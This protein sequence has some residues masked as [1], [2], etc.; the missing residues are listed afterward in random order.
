MPL[1]LQ[2]ETY[3]SSRPVA[4]SVF[5]VTD[6]VLEGETSVYSVQLEGPAAQVIA[7]TD[8]TVIT[9]T[10]VDEVTH[11]VINS[12]TEQD[13]LDI[14]G[15]SI[16]GNNVV[17]SPTALLTWTAQALDNIIVDPTDT[18]TIEWHRAIFRFEF[19]IGAGAEVGLHEVRIPVKRAFQSFLQTLT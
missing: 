2:S 1:V 16:G 11:S 18:V 17:I 5:V 3:S 6:A 13:I 10:L 19:D 8:F 12:R 15:G 7:N 4:R 9:L 14:G